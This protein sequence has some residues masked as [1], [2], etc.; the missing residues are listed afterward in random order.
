MLHIRAKGRQQS[1]GLQRDLQ[2]RRKQRSCAKQ[3]A[4]LSEDDMLGKLQSPDEIFV[5]PAS[6]EGTVE[7]DIIP[8]ADLPPDAQDE[9]RRNTRNP[10]VGSTLVSESDRAR[11]WHIEMQPGDRLEFHRHVLDYFWTTTASGRA[12]S[13]Y[14]DGRVV[15]ADYPLGSTKNYRIEKGGSFMHDLENIGDT[16]LS[17]VTVEYLDSAN[18]ALPLPRDLQRKAA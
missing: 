11:I 10:R 17:F 15:D 1:C 7:F 12:R 5:V 9:V 3:L 16:V 18:E 6:A 14:A 2:N 13:R 8:S 4:L